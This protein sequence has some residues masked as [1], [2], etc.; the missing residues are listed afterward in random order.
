MKDHFVKAFNF[1]K[2]KIRSCGELQIPDGLGTATCIVCVGKR[3]FVATEKNAILNVAVK[4]N[5]IPNHLAASVPTK[6]SIPI[7]LSGK[8]FDANFFFPDK[9]LPSQQYKINTFNSE[10]SKNNG[11]FSSWNE[12]EVARGY[13]QGLQCACA[14]NQLNVKHRTRKG[15]KLDFYCS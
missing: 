12:H 5:L 13:E 6:P 3:L 8:L 4:L 15:T 1:K 11:I 10:T 9:S 7:H 14:M 2:S